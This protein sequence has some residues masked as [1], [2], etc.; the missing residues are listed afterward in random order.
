MTELATY[1][2]LFAANIGGQTAR[3]QCSTY[4]GDRAD[5]R[6]CSSA[7]GHDVFEVGQ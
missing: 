2:A 1:I 6:G 7:Y 4:G 5:L 3:R